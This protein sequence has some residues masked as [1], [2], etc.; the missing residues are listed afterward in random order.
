MREVISGQ[1]PAVF[2]PANIFQVLARR[3]YDTVLTF[4]VFRHA[5]ANGP[6]NCSCECKAKPFRG[7]FC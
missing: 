7:T 5:S 1:F 4:L 6:I 2:S 3:C